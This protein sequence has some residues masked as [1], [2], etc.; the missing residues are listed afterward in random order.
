MDPRWDGQP[1]QVRGYRDAAGQI[2][3]P[4]GRVDLAAH[5]DAWPDGAVW[6]ADLQS[7]AAFTR[8]GRINNWDHDPEFL[9]GDFASLKDIH[10]GSGQPRSLRPVRRPENSV[11]SL[12]VLDRLCRY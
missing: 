10:H 3:L 11:R 12:Q 4:F 9:E 5:P 2:T 1:Y 6:P 8:R 7:E